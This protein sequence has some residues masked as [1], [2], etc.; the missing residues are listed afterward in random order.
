[1]REKGNPSTPPT[2]SLS[3]TPKR[4]GPGRPGFRAARDAANHALE[5]SGRSFVP[6]ADQH[7]FVAFVSIAI[8][9]AAVAIAEAP[10]V[11]MWIW[12][13]PAR[14]GNAAEAA[15]N[16]HA[17]LRDGVCRDRAHRHGSVG[18][19]SPPRAEHRRNCRFPSER[20]RSSFVM[21]AVSAP[22]TDHRPRR[23]P[24]SASRASCRS[25]KPVEWS[26][27][28]R[29]KQRPSLVVSARQRTLR[30]KMRRQRGGAF[31]KAGLHLSVHSNS[32]LPRRLLLVPWAPFA[33]RCGA[34]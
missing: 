23:G 34:C 33:S 19:R 16:A 3:F 13:R 28:V 8:L 7:T 18:Q 5:Q 30:H 6:S 22:A 26:D 1:M 11:A 27:S 20:P 10:F 24:P 9:L 15:A 4:T 25:R 21:K 31:C 32:R 14:A 29:D 2:H 17:D 12:D